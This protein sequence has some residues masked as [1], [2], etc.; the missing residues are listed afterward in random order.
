MELNQD[1]NPFN[2][3]NR[4][5]AKEVSLLNNCD[6]TQSVDISYESDEVGNTI[7]MQRKP[8]QR[9]NRKSNMSTSSIND[10]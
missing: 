2:S 3:K 7:F 1:Y 5:D 8:Q 9:R 6:Q 10:S 4:T